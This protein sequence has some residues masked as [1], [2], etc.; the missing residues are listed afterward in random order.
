MEDF[1]LVKDVLSQIKQLGVKLVIDDFGTGYSSFNQLIKLEVDKLK[2]DQSFILEVEKSEKYLNLVSGILSMADNL[3]IGV[4]CE[5]IEFQGQLKK[6][7]LTNWQLGQGYLFSRPKKI[8]SLIKDF[9][10]I[11]YNITDK[12]DSRI[13]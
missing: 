9:D 2:I 1:N 3:N 10:E 13:N 8:G 12:F 6:M 4:V 5:G 7:F 11:V